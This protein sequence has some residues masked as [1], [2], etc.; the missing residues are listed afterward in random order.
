MSERRTIAIA[1]AGIGGLTAALA[2]ARAGFGVTIAERARALSTI[3]AGIQIAPNAGRVLAQLGL[4]AA[5]AARAT[6]LEAIVIRSGR[7][8]GT[9]AAIPAA[10]FRDRTGMPYRVIHRADL[11]AVLVEAVRAEPAIDLRLGTEGGAIH[12]AEATIAADG[13]WSSHRDAMAGAARAAPSGRTAWR[14]TVPVAALPEGARADAVGLWL[15]PGA[16]L[17]HYPV[18]GE[19][20]VNI[21]AIVEDASSDDRAWSAPGDPA[22]LA[23]R[24][25]GWS[26]EARAV[27]AA[28]SAWQTFALATVDAGGPWVAGSTALL[29]DAAHAMLPFLAQGAAMAIED[30]AV[31]AAAL[32]A[33]SDVAAALAAYERERRPR[34]ARVA[35]ASARTGAWY[36]ATGAR[37][38]AR[39]AALRIGGAALVLGM[40]DW[41]YRWRPPDG[42]RG[43]RLMTPIRRSNQ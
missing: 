23:A 42:P 34:V 22:L 17:I 25:A 24:F 12:N 11:Q 5:I 7:H 38:V 2:L 35:V 30:A 33:T 14:A 41:I 43:P 21:V 18:G 37:A 39:D 32:A 15:G 27:V 1:G 31:L 10:A 4:E 3:G 20:A 28:P 16:H 9:L 13:V 26:G 29:G 36:H 40:N 19:T 6:E 8:G